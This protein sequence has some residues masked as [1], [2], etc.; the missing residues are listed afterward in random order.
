MTATATTPYEIAAEVEGTAREFLVTDDPRQAAAALWV[1]ATARAAMA[2]HSPSWSRTANQD[3]GLAD[4]LADLA[5]ARVS[6]T[7]VPV[8]DLT[9]A[10]F[11][12]DEATTDAFY[13]LTDP[14]H[15]P[16]EIVASAYAIVARACVKAGFSPAIPRLLADLWQRYSQPR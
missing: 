11:E 15:V 1:F 13:A 6:G 5:A 4:L 7:A 2:D 16:A 3:A 12:S 8:D 10:L 14:G 9:T